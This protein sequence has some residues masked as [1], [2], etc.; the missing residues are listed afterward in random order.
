MKYRQ[1]FVSN[2]SSSSFII[3]NKEEIKICV[4][5]N[6]EYY[7]ISDILTYLD[8]WYKATKLIKE[9][10]FDDKVVPCFL[11]ELMGF[12]DCNDSGTDYYDKLKK[13]CDKN[14]EVCLTIT[15]DRDWIYR[16]NINLEL[17]EGD[18]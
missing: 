18:L 17:F 13:L 11:S 12:Y 3:N 14:P 2:S 15:C 1:G 5:N 6:I 4:D 9:M 7:K 10:T 8:A 16:K